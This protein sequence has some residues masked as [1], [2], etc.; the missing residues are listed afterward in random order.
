MIRSAGEGLALQDGRFIVPDSWSDSSEVS[1][2]PGAYP[3]P[4][5]DSEG[6]AADQRVPATQ[7]GRILIG[8]VCLISSKDSESPLAMVFYGYMFL[9]WLLLLVLVIFF[10]SRVAQAMFLLSHIHDKMFS[11]ADRED[12]DG[13]KGP[14]RRSYTPRTASLVQENDQYEYNVQYHHQI[15]LKGKGQVPVEGVVL[16]S[17]D[18]LR[19]DRKQGE[20]HRCQDEDVSSNGD[21]QTNNEER[22][23]TVKEGNS[24][25]GQKAVDPLEFSNS[26]GQNNGQVP[27][28]ISLQTDD[29]LTQQTVG[30][31]KT[32][33]GKKL[34]VSND[35]VYETG[36]YETSS[37]LN[38][39]QS[40]KARN[41]L[42]PNSMESPRSKSMEEFLK[43]NP[44]A[45]ITGPK[46]KSVKLRNLSSKRKS[47]KI[48]K[49][50]VS[51]T[52]GKS[53]SNDILLDG[54]ADKHLFL[55][56]AS[57]NSLLFRR[58]KSMENVNAV[59]KLDCLQV[60]DLRKHAS[61]AMSKQSSENE[62]HKEIG[63]RNTLR[64]TAA[65]IGTLTNSSTSL[66]YT[67]SATGSNG[68]ESS[69]A[70][71]Y[72]EKTLT[73][74]RSSA[75]GKRN[76]CVLPLTGLT[77]KAAIQNQE[78]EEQKKIMKAK[79]KAATLP[80]SMTYGVLAAERAGAL[81]ERRGSGVDT[82]ENP[83][84]GVEVKL[85]PKST[86]SRSPGRRT[87]EIEDM[88][89]KPTF[90]LTNGQ[91]ADLNDAAGKNIQR[92]R[93]STADI[94]SERHRRGTLHPVRTSRMLF[95]ISLAFLVSFLP[96]FVIVLMRSSIGSS[97]FL[98]SLSWVELGAVSI[99]VR[100]T[101][102]SNAVNP[103]I[104]GLLS[105][106]FRRECTGLFRCF[107]RK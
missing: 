95:I 25:A 29:S 32:S 49:I 28:Q 27:F 82:L 10:Y 90:G 97:S 9:S 40:D 56:P 8:N 102:L 99:F 20:G 42:R 80:S 54:G 76:V 77:T 59:P 92:A 47:G 71:N 37:C 83:R 50:K 13:S 67:S 74:T 93:P 15:G 57:T 35:S 19:S 79:A 68:N 63:L 31:S 17:H 16:L 23:E 22:C 3:V 24:S 101:L 52:K 55:H 21:L 107:V 78:S 6:E 64:E 5:A 86:F 30:N 33:T 75:K 73:L 69:E 43:G 48:P 98:S 53:K 51:E 14:T 36:S 89:G 88:P 65:V 70:K 84:F 26:K 94:L 60:P 61:P 45:C 2:F 41:K 18:A 1:T 100:S 105:T 44:E 58:I 96:F 104:Y 7:V 39:D 72:T 46:R 91:N 12:M 38:L 34:E 85:R 103:V 106:H 87:V 4:Y 11:L 62:A 66:Q 81:A